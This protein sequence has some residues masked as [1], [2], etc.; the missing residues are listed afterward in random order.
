MFLAS[1]PRLAEDVQRAIAMNM[2]YRGCLTDPNVPGTEKV[3]MTMVGDKW[4]KTPRTRISSADLNCD[5]KLLPPQVAF[6]AK[7]WNRSCAALSVL[8]AAFELGNVLIQ[9]PCPCL[10]HHSL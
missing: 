4:L 6:A 5:P 2:M 8:R 1:V 7:G 3:V 9:A 10:I